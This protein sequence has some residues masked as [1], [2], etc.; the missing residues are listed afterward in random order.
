M[1]IHGWLSCN[2]SPRSRRQFLC[3]MFEHRYCGLENIL[4]YIVIIVVAHIVYAIWNRKQIQCDFAVRLKGGTAHVRKKKNRYRERGREAR[5]ILT[6]RRRRQSVC[7]FGAPT[8]ATESFSR[9]TTPPWLQTDRKTTTRKMIS[10]PLQPS[11]TK[12]R[13]AAIS[14][15]APSRT[16][17]GI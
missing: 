6:R 15:P 17:F 2:C 5:T 8:A 14:R 1:T 7:L 4:K 12:P 13:S 16:A 10:T 9:P 3:I 11:S